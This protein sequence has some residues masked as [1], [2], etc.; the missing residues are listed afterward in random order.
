MAFTPEQP[1]I[2]AS[3]GDISVTLTDYADAETPDAASYE[4]QVLQADGT[5]FRLATGDLTP[6][7]TPQQIVALQNFMAD[8]RV[9]AQGLLPGEA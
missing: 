9:L 2:P 8:M 6:H 1:E 7:L 5:M 3:I 4:V